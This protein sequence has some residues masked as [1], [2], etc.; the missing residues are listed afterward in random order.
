[1]SKCWSVSLK[2]LDIKCVCLLTFARWQSKNSRFHALISQ[3]MDGHINFCRICFHVAL[4]PGCNV[5]WIKRKIFRLRG[6][7]MYGQTVE[8]DISQYSSI[9]FILIS[10]RRNDVLFSKICYISVSDFWCQRNSWR[11][12]DQPNYAHLIGVWWPN[13]SPVTPDG[14]YGNFSKTVLVLLKRRQWVAN[15]H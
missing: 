12:T 11:L 1:M 15:D 9:S 6:R 4:L 8:S 13:R 7:G 2:W 5:E 14:R 10:R 3:F